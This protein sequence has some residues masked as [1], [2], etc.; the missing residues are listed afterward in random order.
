MQCHE[1]S[2]VKNLIADEVGFRIVHYR[3]AIKSKKLIITFDAHGHDLR[4]AGFATDV[5]I[6]AGFD[7]IFVSHLL[8]SQY[9]LLSLDAFKGFVEP[10]L[11]GYEVYTYGSSLGG[12][13]AIYYAGGIDARAI[14]LSPRNS[15]HPSINDEF[16]AHVK[17]AHLDIAETKRSRFAPI[18]VFDPMQTVDREFIRRY[19]VP[20]YPEVRLQEMNYAGHL[21]AEALLEVGLL[22]EFFLSIVNNDALMSV[23]FSQYESSYWCAEIAYE[24]I[25]YENPMLAASYLLRSLRI[26]HDPAHLDALINLVRKESLP[27]SFL[28][29]V[30]D[31]YVDAIRQSGI[32]DENWYLAFYEDVASDP[33]FS[34]DPLAHYLLHGGYEGRNP[35]A[36][37]N[38]AAYLNAFQD[39]RDS[40]INPL[41]H[42]ILYGR[43][44]DR[45]F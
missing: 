13:C 1:E 9:Q 27:S 36:D 30:L 12:Y 6:E 25:K 3:H 10:L 38:S 37:F 14:A 26:R 18:V 28:S 32:F 8:H 19:I 21:I 2:V 5:C 34:Q 24:E 35:C 23:D 42:Y 15:A 4:D 41:L 40:G 31:P 20:A 16:F 7:H 43:A 44:E 45:S 33:A 17:F 22:K 39:V 29:G 11:E